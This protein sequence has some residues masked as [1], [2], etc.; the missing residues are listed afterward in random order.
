[1]GPDHGSIFSWLDIVSQYKIRDLPLDVPV[2]VEE[3]D[4]ARAVV[5][6]GH[7]ARARVRRHAHGL[8]QPRRADRAQRR[9]LHRHLPTKLML[10]IFISSMITAIC[11]FIVEGFMAVSP[12]SPKDCV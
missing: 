7:A 4:G 2:R 3:E 5:G 9:A 11:Q 10:V 6:H 8:H 1:M 12:T